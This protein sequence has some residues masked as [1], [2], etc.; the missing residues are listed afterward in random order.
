L[1][2]DPPTEREEAAM[3]DS[4]TETEPEGE[5]LTCLYPGCER[6]AVP[7][8]K[9]GGPPPRYCDEEGHNA[10]STY[11]ALHGKKDDAAEG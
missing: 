2:G 11:Q 3:S 8:P 9:F 4:E 6:D 5:V 7:G 10:A 1:V